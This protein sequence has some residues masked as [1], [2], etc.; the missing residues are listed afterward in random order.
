MCI[1]DSFNAAKNGSKSVLFGFIFSNAAPDS[2]SPV[3]ET[4]I[5]NNSE[6]TDVI[7]IYLKTNFGFSFAKVKIETAASEGENLLAIYNSI[8]LFQ[9]TPLANE[10]ASV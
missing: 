2:K 10:S 7:A 5:Y 8:Y 3:N 4:I 6:N 1:R 9:F